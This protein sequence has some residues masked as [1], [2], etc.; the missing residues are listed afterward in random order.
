MGGVTSARL[1]L[2]ALLWLLTLQFFVVEAVVAAR[3]DGYSYADKTISL[4]GASTSPAQVA[5]NVS[6]VVQGLLI[7]GGLVLLRPVLTGRGT[8]VA[9]A[10]LAAASTTTTAQR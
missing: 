3:Y 4:L 2:G 5:M 10:M 7:L 1:R 6:F 8:T 9:T